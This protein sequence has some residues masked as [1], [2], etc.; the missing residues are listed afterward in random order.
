MWQEPQL[1]LETTVNT[2]DYSHFL[3][4]EVLSLYNNNPAWG[5]GQYLWNLTPEVEKQSIHTGKIS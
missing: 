5:L 1:L 3:A 4:Q 2:T